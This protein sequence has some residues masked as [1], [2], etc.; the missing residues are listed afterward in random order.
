[1]S[2][3]L[4]SVDQPLWYERLPG[5]HHWSGRVRRGTV[6][7]F[8]AEASNANLSVL[9]FNAEEKLERYNMPDTLKAQH[10]AFLTAGH[11]CYSDMG[12]VMCSIIRDDTG[13][14][15]T[16]CGVADASQIQAQ[17]GSKTFGDARNAMFRNGRDGFLVEMEKWGLG[18]QDLVANINLFSKVSADDHDDNQ[19]ALVW[20]EQHSKADNIIELRF[21]METLLILSS[22]PHP[23]NPATIYQPADI[24]IT[25]YKANPIAPDDLCRN[26]CPQNQRGFANNAR[27]FAEPSL[28]QF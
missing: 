2:Y 13:W 28:S 15:D 8:K 25:A 17:Y 21:E 7:Q 9:F 27:Y 5:G 11:V 14:I 26:S 18:Q 4:Y 1:M 22:A 24:S 12:R 19:G 10:T 20:A 3:S 16:L 6:L 23:L